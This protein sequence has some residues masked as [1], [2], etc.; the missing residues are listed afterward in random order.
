MSRLFETPKE[1]LKLFVASKVPIC[2]I[3]GDSLMANGH[4]FACNQKLA[5][6]NQMTVSFHQCKLCR[7]PVYADQFYACSICWSCTK[8]SRVSR[9]PGFCRF[10]ESGNIFNPKI[11]RRILQDQPNWILCALLDATFD[12]LAQNATKPCER[13]ILD[14]VLAYL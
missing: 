12:F 6:A 5:R 4:C 7:I 13:F 14:L 11:L 9:L 3:H 10:C 8:C 2:V 1:Y